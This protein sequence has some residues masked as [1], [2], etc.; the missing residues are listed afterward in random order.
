M[1]E[2]DRAYVSWYAEG[3]L[4]VDISDPYRPIE[5][6]RYHKEGAAFELTN[7]GPQDL[8][9]VYKL[10]GEPWIYVSDR[11]GGLYVIEEVA[12][13]ISSP[14]ALQPAGR[15]WPDIKK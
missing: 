7:G 15:D 9:G 10:P 13:G 5:L 11:N 14:E 12:G 3:L 6:A 8:W 1:V 2:G 4:I